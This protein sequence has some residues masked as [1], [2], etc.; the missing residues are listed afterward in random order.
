MRSQ[1][2]RKSGRNKDGKTADNE[3]S[4]KKITNH[5]NNKDHK[6]GGEDLRTYIINKDQDEWAAIQKIKSIRMYHYIDSITQK[7]S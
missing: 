3:H 7:G 2:R 4:N 6:I 1:L 5:M